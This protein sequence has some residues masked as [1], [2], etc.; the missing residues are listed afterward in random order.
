M[1][2]PAAQPVPEIEMKAPFIEKAGVRLIVRREDLNHPHISGNKYWKLKYNLLEA[3]KLGH[4]TVLTF[5]GAFSNHIAATA[6]ACKAVGLKSIGIIRGEDADLSNPTLAQALKNGMAL[7]R[8][9]RTKYKEKE[10]PSFAD[11]MRTLFGDFFL[12]PEGG[13]NHLAIQGASEMVNRID[14]PYDYL[15]LPVGTGGTMA[16]CIDCLKG[17]RQIIGFSALK[18]NFLTEEIIALQ[19]QHSLSAFGNWDMINNYHFGG[20]G[21]VKDDL[22]VFVKAF[23][24]EFAIPLEPVYTGKMMF[25]L[26]EMIKNAYFRKGSVIYTIHTGGLQGRAGFRRILA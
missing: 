14:T 6:A 24:D 7:H 10:L 23:E 17:K 2:Y 26:L 3:D 11:E 25:G 13:T 1:I 15:A 18:G 4:H 19:R 5:G 9:S 21:K 20:Y 16:G 8:I 22:I 12:I